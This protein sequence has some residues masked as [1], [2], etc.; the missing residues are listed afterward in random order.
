MPVSKL[1]LVVEDEESMRTIYDIVLRQKLG[2]EVLHA[3]DGAEALEILEN[4]A[5]DIVFLDILL[6]RVNGAHVLTYIQTA[7]HLASTRVVIVSAHNHLLQTGT[8][9]NDDQFLLKPVRVHDIQRVVNN[10][11][12]TL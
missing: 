1:A 3:Q 7:A 2:F 6:P 10:L 12:S 11:P 8:L 5:P 9:R 4:R